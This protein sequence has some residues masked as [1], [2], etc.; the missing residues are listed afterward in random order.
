MVLGR[1]KIPYYLVQAAEAERNA[2]RFADP[3]T[4]ATFLL[5][6]ETW[7]K[8]SGHGR[9]RKSAEPFRTIYSPGPRRV[10]RRLVPS[11]T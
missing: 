5:L 6:A 9:G 7:R 2:E 11:P 8:L 3:E 4:K 1:S 10:E